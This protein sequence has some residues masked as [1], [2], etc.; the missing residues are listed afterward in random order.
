MSLATFVARVFASSCLSNFILISF[1]PSFINTPVFESSLIFI[2]FEPDDS[3]SFAIFV[4][5][6][7][8]FCSCLAELLKFA[9]SVANRVLYWLA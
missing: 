5:S 7:A 6:T 9:I 4:N 3:K 8:K 2:V 1:S